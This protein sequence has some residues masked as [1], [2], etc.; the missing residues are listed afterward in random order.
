MSLLFELVGQLAPHASLFAGRMA[1]G[2]MEGVI[3]RIT[4]RTVDGGEGVFRRLIG[5]GGQNPGGPAGL[6]EPDAVELDA[7][8]DRL[9]EAERAQ[10]AA[11][12]T[13]WLNGSPDRQDLNELVGAPASVPVPAPAPAPS[14]TVNSTG[15]NNIVIGN[16]GTF[17]QQ[18]RDER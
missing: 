5:R 11:A 15:D 9:N 17:T 2:A 16:V 10:L 8:L 6:S 13:T 12:L 7:L 14:T 4:D 1:D 3:Q 18:L